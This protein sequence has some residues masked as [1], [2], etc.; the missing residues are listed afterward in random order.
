MMN[1]IAIIINKISFVVVVIIVVDTN[2]SVK[3]YFST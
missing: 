2:F 1:V 3:I